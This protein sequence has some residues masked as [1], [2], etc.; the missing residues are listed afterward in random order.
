M[1]GYWYRE[2][3][4]LDPQWLTPVAFGTRYLVP[5]EGDSVLK[6]L[7][8]RGQPQKGERET[9]EYFLANDRGDLEGT[10]NWSQSRSLAN[11][12]LFLLWS[13]A[14]AQFAGRPSRAVPYA[15]LL[16]SIGPALKDFNVNSY[17][18]LGGSFHHLGRYRDELQLASRMEARIPQEVKGRRSIRVGAFAGLGDVEGMRRVLAE[19]EGAVQDTSSTGTMTFVAGIELAAH[20]RAEEGAALLRES[21]SFYRRAREER[22]DFAWADNE[23]QALRWTG[24]LDSAEALIRRLVLSGKRPDLETMFLGGLGVIAAQRGQRAQ[25]LAYTRRLEVPATRSDVADD[26]AY[27]RAGISAQLGDREEAVRLL[28]GLD[29]RNGRFRFGWMHRDLDLAP[30]RGYPPFEA[31]LKPKD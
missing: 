27:Y 1:A 28:Q 25:A 26:A 24:A 9:L 20:G 6:A 10:S 16:D 22:G 2:A 14:H 5:S 18:F 29:R 13:L 11:P 31:L 23:V 12:E 7:A 3:E 30:L 19:S 21:L 8:L 4:R 15:P 17:V